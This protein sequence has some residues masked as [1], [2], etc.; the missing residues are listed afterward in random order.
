MAG[1]DDQMKTILA[2]GPGFF[3]ANTSKS[4]KS[5]PDGS[6]DIMCA[7]LEIYRI[8]GELDDSLQFTLLPA[9]AEDDPRIA[10]LLLRLGEVVEK[11]K[12][13]LQA[14]AKKGS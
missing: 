10:R 5:I 13:L 4:D 3:S 12:E 1:W 6:I 11:N 14:A 7:R 8:Q 9:M 2:T